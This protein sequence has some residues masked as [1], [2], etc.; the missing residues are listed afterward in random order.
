[1]LEALKNA[2]LK[3][4]DALKNNGEHRASLADAIVAAHDYIA[5]LEGRVAMLE[6]VVDNG[7]A[8]AQSAAA[9][10]DA[11]T[12]AVTGTGATAQQSA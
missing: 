10:V 7:F 5:H 12:V 8:V 9:V 4:V 3:A 6:R 2:V 11:A 1:M